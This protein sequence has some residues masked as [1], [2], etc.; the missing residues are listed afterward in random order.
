V[1]TT[2]RNP[3]TPAGERILETASALFYDRGIRAVGVDLI[4]DEAGTTKKTLYDRFGS[5][6]ELVAAYLNRRAGRWVDFLTDHLDRQA[7]DPGPRRVLA[8]VDALEEWLSGQDRG[9]AFVNAYAEIGGTDHPGNE[10]IRADKRFMRALFV[11]LV[12]EA[13]IPEP[14]LVGAQLH[15]LYEGAIVARTAG[16]MEKAYDEAR[17]AMHRLLAA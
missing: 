8:V 16:G 1:S 6:D 7:P 12:G 5:K 14:D 11:R 9:C 13:G 3:H 4:A 17:A 10:V 15:L 2:T